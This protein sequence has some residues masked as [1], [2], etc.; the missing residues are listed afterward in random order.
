LERT[1]LLETAAATPS[2]KTSWMR[3]S[4]GSMRFERQPL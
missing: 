2:F 3:M 1:K 4:R